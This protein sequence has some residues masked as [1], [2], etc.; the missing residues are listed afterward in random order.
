MSRREIREHLFRM[1]FLRDFHKEEELD[2]QIGFYF[3]A[4]EAK[5]EELKYLKDRFLLILDKIPEIDEL[6]A[7]ASSGWK[8]N[9]MGK[10]DLT[11]LRLA[12]FEIKFDEDIPTKVAI[13]EAV[14][15][16]KIFGGDSSGSFIN[17]VLAK[18]A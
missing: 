7:V 14:E 4:I 13:N 6:L 12:I 17:G 9:R 15:I 1:L 11:I 18:L 10:V 5:E 2:E 3:E 16:A 8:L